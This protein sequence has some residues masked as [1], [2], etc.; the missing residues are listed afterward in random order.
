[1]GEP[2][3]SQLTRLLHASC[4]WSS[5]QTVKNP[6]AWL[7]TMSP[8]RTAN[9]S[10]T[11]SSPTSRRPLKRPL[12]T[13]KTSAALPPGPSR[14]ILPTQTPR[15]L[16][17]P[18][19]S[20]CLRATMALVTPLL[21]EQRRHLSPPPVTS[22]TATIGR[23]AFLAAALTAVTAVA[24]GASAVT[25]ATAAAAATVR[26]LRAAA[27]MAAPPPAAA[28]VQV[29]P[30]ALAAAALPSSL[31]RRRGTAVAPPDG[32]RLA[33]SELSPYATGLCV[34]CRGTWAAR[35]NGGATEDDGCAD[36]AESSSVVSL[37]CGH[38]YH[39]HCIL[40]WL[41]VRPS[42][43]LCLRQVEGAS[44][45]GGGFRGSIK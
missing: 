43:P 2:T 6:A 21:A 4:R 37:A 31:T 44:S 19:Y 35:P 10:G 26:R 1:M 30:T 22:T 13:S 42:C 36:D 11:L 3:L 41:A 5:L 39:H 15:P 24:V 25:A 45:W 33:A 9:H 34:V 18:C 27:G 23:L 32:F 14:P 29:L 28:P 38:R 12:P 17:P 16:H 20:A 7:W 40:S 8:R